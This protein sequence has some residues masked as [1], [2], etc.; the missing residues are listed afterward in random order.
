MTTEL[1]RHDILAHREM[2]SGLIL[3]AVAPL[4]G[5]TW[6]E[7]FPLAAALQLAGSA[8]TETVSRQS[9]PS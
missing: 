1:D 7:G 8:D 2:V 4:T 6:V 5:W 3:V 9:W